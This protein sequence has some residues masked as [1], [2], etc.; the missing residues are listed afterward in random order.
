MEYGFASWPELVRQVRASQPPG[1]VSLDA[2]RLRCRQEIPEYGGAG[3]PLA[4]VAA[5]NHAGTDIDYMDFVA[6]T[7]WAFS[8][9]YAYADISPAFL[10]VCGDPKSDGPYE[11]F[12]F[13]PER[14]G[15]GYEAA[16]MRDKDRLWPFVAEHVD[17]G[18]PIV[19]EYLDGG[20]I[21]GHRVQDG[22][23]QVY[24]DQTAGAP[25]WLNIDEMNQPGNVY[26][27]VRGREGEPWEGILPEALRRAASK[28]SPHAWGG[29][30]QGMAALE[31]YLADVADP[32]KDFAKCGE[33]FCWAAFERLSARKCAAAWLETLS[34]KLPGSVGRQVSTAARQYHEAFDAYERFRAAVGAGEP[35]PLA[36]HQ[37]A[38]TPDRI[39]M[40]VPILKQGIAAEA[41]GLEAL[42]K[43][44]GSLS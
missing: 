44:A 33:W 34:Q 22:Q 24:Y 11:V 12:R 40:I 27:L 37:R 15:Y 36:L 23:R 20:L 7:G 26:V 10:A 42:A 32:G 14:L 39:S 43:A 17:E 31:A 21:T 30:P 9:G 16:P 4:I 28:G 38:R 19:S 2:V 3:V 41:A 1:G 13:L 35:T 6:S 25:G 5:M 29:V 8:F 18:R